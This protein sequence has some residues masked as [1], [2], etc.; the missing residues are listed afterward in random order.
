MKIDKDLALL[1]GVLL[2]DGCLG[3]VKNYH[4]DISISGNLKD[5]KPFY[6]NI[7][8]PIIFKLRQK[9]NKI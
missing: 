3:K 5:D 4:Y 7:L 2:G 6:D 9:R 1:Y 8:K